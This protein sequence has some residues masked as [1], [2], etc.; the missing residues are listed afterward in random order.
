MDTSRRARIFRSKLIEE[1]HIIENGLK[2]GKDAPKHS[3][4]IVNEPEV[5]ENVLLKDPRTPIK[6]KIFKRSVELEKKISKSEKKYLRVRY[7]KGTGMYRVW[8]H[9][10]VASPT[11]QT[12]ITIL[13]VI[14]T[15]I[16]AIMDGKLVPSLTRKSDLEYVIWEESSDGS[17]TAFGHA[18]T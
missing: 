10:L 5:F 2:V 7:R 11:F 13:I 3:T 1:F 16:M 4:D 8:V 6:F 14:N 17:S 15:G 18:R 9:W 12:T